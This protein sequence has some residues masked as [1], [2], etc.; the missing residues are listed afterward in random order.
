MHPW[1]RMRDYRYY[2]R[3][4]IQPVWGCY[5]QVFSLLPVSGLQEGVRTGVEGEYT[6]EDLLFASP[7]F[8]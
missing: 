4:W 5:L 7:H 2:Y 8:L 6:Q 3:A 1:K